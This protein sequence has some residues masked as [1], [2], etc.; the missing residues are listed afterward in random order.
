MARSRAMKV[1]NT[2]S[3]TQGDRCP[4]LPPWQGGNAH[5]TIT[6]RPALHNDRMSDSGRHDDHHHVLH[7]S[8]CIACILVAAHLPVT[9]SD[10]SPGSADA[11]F[12]AQSCALAPQRGQPPAEVGVSPGVLPASCC[13]RSGPSCT[14][15]TRT[16]GSRSALQPVS[17]QFSFAMMDSVPHCS[18]H[19]WVSHAWQQSSGPGSVGLSSGTISTLA[20]LCAC[21]N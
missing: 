2:P 14:P 3:S 17:H 9:A 5:T 7:T 13:T 1:R 8:A 10:S 11:P 15:P 4:P 19:S 6:S 20:G 16:P 21:P 12:A 18:Q